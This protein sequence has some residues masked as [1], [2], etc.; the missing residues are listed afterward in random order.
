MNRKDVDGQQ[1]LRRRLP[2]A[3]QHRRLR[4]LAS[5]CPPAA[6]WN[7]P[8][9]PRGWPSTAPP[10]SPWRWS[11]PSDDPAYEDIASQVLRA[12]RRHRR[13]D[14]HAG[15]HGPVG[16]ERRLLLRPARSTDGHPPLRVRSLVGLIPLFA[17]EV[18]DE[19]V[20]DRLPG[21]QQAA[22]GG[23]WRTGRTWPRHITYR[24]GAGRGRR[25]RGCW[26]SLPRERLQRVLRYVL[27]ETEF[28]SPY[29][30]R[31]LSRVHS[32][33]PYVF[34]WTA[35]SPRWTTCPGESDTGMFGGN[36]NW[37]GP[38]WF[39]INYL[40]IEALERYHHFYGD[41]T[42]GGVPHRL[43]TDDDPPRRGPGALRGG[44]GALPAGRPR[45]TPAARRPGPLRRGPGVQGAGPLLR[46]LS[47]RHRPGLGA[48]HQTGWTALAIA[49]LRDVIVQRRECAH[50]MDPAVRDA[51]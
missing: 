1:P 40:L 48:S 14:E 20:I 47:R 50:R 37:R 49:A 7:R 31:S 51:P 10:C 12:L 13:R 36:S 3:R 28:L 39:P 22:C 26:P 42:A 6:T 46:V 21:L 16:R 41:S 18:L 23:S 29:G 43:G 44:C 32:E 30:I 19:A 35:R 33:H 8:T 9:A 24:S 38:V 45:A 15:R 2:R 4:P 5:R 27:D 17:A 25:A 11:S 34:D